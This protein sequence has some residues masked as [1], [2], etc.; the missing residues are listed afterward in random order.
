MNT[1]TNTRAQSF[2]CDGPAELD[3][4]IRGGRIAVRTTDSPHVRVE[5]SAEPGDAGPLEGRVESAL[6]TISDGADRPEDADQHF[7][8]ETQVTFSEQ[9]R[10][11]VVRAPRSFRRAGIAVVV[12]APEHSRLKA[13]AHRGSISASGT[14]D[15]LT[16]A[17]GAGAIA[18]EDVDGPVDIATGS[19]LVRLGRVTGPLRARL[20]SGEVEAASIE[21]GGANVATGHG[22]V[23]L[24]VVR[25]DANVR[26]GTGGIIVAE[27]ASGTISLATGSGDLR[28][29]IRPGVSAELDVLSGSGLVRSELEVS[30]HAPAD[31]PVARIRMRTGKGEAVVERAAS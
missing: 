7:V 3:I 9:R 22:D 19:G 2:D 10:K 4:R 30:G 21:G 31:A 1:Q 26:T 11:L 16:A 20:G 15:Q 23:W 8:D 17:A 29:G 25:C 13:R 28:V 6:G 14:L 18:A 5:I 24:G 12:E 27:A